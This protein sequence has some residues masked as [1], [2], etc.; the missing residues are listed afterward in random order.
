MISVKKQTGQLA[1][2]LHSK[3]VHDVVIS[4]GSRNGP[5]VH[6]LAGCGKFNCRSIVD[7]RSAG[8]FAIGL[9]Q[10]LKKPVAMVCSS[11]TA[12]LNFAPAVAEA[13][14]LGIPLIVL[15]ADRPGYW[16]GQGENQTIS[17]GNI[18]KDFCKKEITLP[19][20]ESEKDLW[21]AARIINEALNEAVS[22]IPGPVHLNI[23][24]EEP[25]HELTDEDLPIV[26]VIDV[27]S[28]KRIVPEEELEKLAE[29]LNNTDHVM[30]LAGQQI[31]HPEL[32][33]VLAALSEKTGAVVLKEHISNLNHL[34]FCTG[35]D[36]LL[37]SLLAENQEN[38]APELL[39]TFGGTFV[40]K[41]LRQ[42]LRNVRPKNHWHLSL[43]PRYYDTYQSLTRIIETEALSFFKQLL[44]KAESKSNHY[45]SNW[46]NK[47]KQ[48]TQ[49]RNEFITQTG[50]CDL[51]VFNRIQEQ[52]PMHSVVHLGN[53]SPVRYALICDAAK[54]VIYMGN[55][56]TSGIDGSLSTAAGF[57]S[58][59][60]KLNT[61]ILGDLSFFYDSNALWNKYIGQNLRI[62]V[63][64]NGGGNIF[65]MIKGPGESP[66]FR[67]FF[68]TENKTSAA[69]IAQTFGLDYFKA[70]N[71]MELETGLKA[72]YSDN[73]K[74]AVLLEIFTD[75]ELNANKFRE[76][77]KRVK[78]A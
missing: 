16:I 41:P 70:E 4:P 72:L 22:G 73:Q 45:H 25:L 37:T 26:K 56:G 38:F 11:G 51:S 74:K 77:F 57:A 53:S 30:I 44:A 63:I 67:E 61:I 42:F 66:S 40:S 59:S 29:V 24:L 10:A 17:Q 15:T 58:A 14:Y 18:Y 35:I 62:I 5:L 33:N 68:F 46:K 78:N 54:D 13:F 64:H 71:E 32:E 55:R 48:V 69:G 19:M 60:D 43:S 75:A 76:L 3:G 52:V 2:L 20:G 9:A 36:I 6:T 65:S 50:F 12:T 31:P 1:S 27:T 39:I 23:P 8:Y 34:Q 7:E 28:S 21:H 49:L 47:E